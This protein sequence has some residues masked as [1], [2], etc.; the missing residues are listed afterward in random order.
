M[1]KKV[2]IIEKIL[3]I[4][5]AG[6][7]ISSF[8]PAQAFSIKDSLDKA[9]TKIQ[10]YWREHKVF[11]VVVSSGKVVAGIALLYW[12]AKNLLNVRDVEIQ[13]RQTNCNDAESRYEAAAAYL[14][15]LRKNNPTCNISRKY[16]NP[17]YLRKYSEYVGLFETKMLASLDLSFARFMGSFWH[18]DLVISF[19]ALFGYFLIG[20][21]LMELKKELWDAN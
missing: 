14:D 9:K 7:M 10:R 20:F 3:A 21:G 16:C 19:P 5:V 8:M 1:F 6:M 4:M 2:S 13:R 17:A 18:N 11:R 12:K 15:H